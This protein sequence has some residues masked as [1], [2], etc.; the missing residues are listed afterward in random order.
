MLESKN[1]DFIRIDGKTQQKKRQS[2]VDRFQNQ[3]KCKVAVLSILAAGCGLTLTAANKVIFAELYWNPGSLLQAEDRVH[4]IGQ[5][6]PITVEYLIGKGTL[7]EHVWNL[8]GSKLDVLGKTLNG[9]S[10]ELNAEMDYDKSICPAKF[11]SSSILYGDFIEKILES[12]ATNSIKAEERRNERL[13]KLMEEE[14][15][16][17]EGDNDDDEYNSYY[18]FDD[19]NDKYNTKSIIATT[20]KSKI[21]SDD[22]NTTGDRRLDLKKLYSYQK[23][24][25]KIEHKKEKKNEYLKTPSPQKKILHKSN[26]I[27]V[28]MDDEFNFSQSSQSTTNNQFHH[29]ELLS[30]EDEEKGYCRK[31]PR[32]EIQPLNGFE[33]LQTFSFTPNKKKRFI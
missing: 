29:Q 31:R 26:K 33:K 21:I 27:I 6:Y 18:N 4:R 7:D 30:S 19:D 1:I 2:L 10:I 3:P 24:K 23:Q 5:K 32:D 13:K 12:V 9:E 14:K 22:C 20:N 17:K 8:I 28:K 11:D 25:E 15:K 16:E